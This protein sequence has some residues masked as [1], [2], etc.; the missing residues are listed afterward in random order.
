[1]SMAFAEQSTIWF[2]V[3]PGLEPR[4]ILYTGMVLKKNYLRKTYY[5]DALKWHRKNYHAYMPTAL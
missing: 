5:Q 2:N 1:M 4:K 3:P